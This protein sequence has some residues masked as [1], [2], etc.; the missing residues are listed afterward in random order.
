MKFFFSFPHPSENYYSKS[1]PANQD[2]SRHVPL[3]FGAV[4]DAMFSGAILWDN[5]D[6]ND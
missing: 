6:I 4:R 2:K 3:L 5:T 1:E